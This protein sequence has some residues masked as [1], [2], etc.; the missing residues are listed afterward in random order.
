MLYT[1]LTKKALKISFDAHKNQ[2]D[3][4]GMPYVYHPFHLAE[5]MNDE[6]STCVAL[7]HDV[8][9]DTDIT[10]DDLKSKGFPDEVIEALVL[11]T[12]KDGVPYLDYVRAMKDNPIARKVKLA[13]LAHNSDLTRLDKVDDKA[14]ERINKY[15]QAAL[16]LKRAER[17][18]KIKKVS[19]K[20]TICCNIVVPDE[21]QFCPSCGKRIVEFKETDFELDLEQTLFS[22][23]K[24]GKVLVLY[25][26]FCG[27]CGKKPVCEIKNNTEL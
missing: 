27:F 24:C 8:A 22:C 4:S 25:G 16:I 18:S 12:H 15:K 19:G 1:D 14:I 7:L 5:Q 3:K 17:Q 10:L 23:G 6:L 20:Q 26:D 11:M 9:E 21:Y 2:V 13:D